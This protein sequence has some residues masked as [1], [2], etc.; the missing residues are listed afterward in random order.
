MI[1]VEKTK[2]SKTIP[3][4]SREYSIFDDDGMRVLKVHLMS[5][6]KGLEFVYTLPNTKLAELFK[7]KTQNAP[8][9]FHLV[10]D[11]NF[12]MVESL[13]DIAKQKLPHREQRNIIF[14]RGFNGQKLIDFVANE[15]KNQHIIDLFADW[16]SQ[17]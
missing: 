7:E 15:C 4:L 12:R 16:N 3:D 13:V 2:S 11:G 1:N 6:Q 14:D 9:L 5:G 10:Y 17:F 8:I